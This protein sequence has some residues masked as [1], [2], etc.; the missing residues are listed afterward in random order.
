MTINSREVEIFIVRVK[1]DDVAFALTDEEGLS[2]AIAFEAEGEIT[3]L[4]KEEILVNLIDAELNYGSPEETNHIIWQCPHCGE[5]SSED[6]CE[7]DT[8]PSLVQC[9]YQRKHENHQPTWAILNWELP[10]R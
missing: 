10:T 9:T 7:G 5:W 1:G 8:P 2:L 6:F 3:T 4:V